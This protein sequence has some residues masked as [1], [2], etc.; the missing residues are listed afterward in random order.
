MTSSPRDAAEPATYGGW[1]TETS[2]FMGGSSLGQFLLM[3][4]A[5]VLVM[6]PV[7]AN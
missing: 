7:Y 5:V 2:G 1:Q 4:A 6:A 3:A